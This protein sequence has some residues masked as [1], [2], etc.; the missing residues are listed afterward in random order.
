MIAPQL[1]MFDCNWFG[2]VY[3]YVAYQLKLSFVD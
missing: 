3:V 2:I 1:Q